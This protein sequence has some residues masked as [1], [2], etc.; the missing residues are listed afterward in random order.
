[1][2]CEAAA[3]S[4]SDGGVEAAEIDE[5]YVTREKQLVSALSSVLHVT[6]GL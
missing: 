6:S 4:E 2:T 1:M 3:G 5:R